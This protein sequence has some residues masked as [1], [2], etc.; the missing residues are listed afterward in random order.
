MIESLYNDSSFNKEYICAPMC[1][2]INK[3]VIIRSNNNILNRD[4]RKE[5]CDT[6][7]SLSQFKIRIQ[8]NNSLESLKFNIVEYRK[9][10]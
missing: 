3:N 8:F 9:K 5:M 10:E 4:F 1:M 7:I 6:T 2:S